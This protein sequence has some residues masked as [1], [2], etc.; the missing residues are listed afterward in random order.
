MVKERSIIV[1][2]PLEVLEFVKQKQEGCTDDQAL[3]IIKRM[4]EAS[5]AQIPT[6]LAMIEEQVNQNSNTVSFKLPTMPKNSTSG[7]QQQTEE[8]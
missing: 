6:V 5:V 2:V 1:K 8:R 7:K 4:S 3:D